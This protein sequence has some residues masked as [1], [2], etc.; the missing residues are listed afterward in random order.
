M[1]SERDFQQGKSQLHTLTLYIW[2]PHGFLVVSP[3]GVPLLAQEKVQLVGLCY[4]YTCIFLSFYHFGVD[5]T[6]Y[7]NLC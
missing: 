2:N 6:V 3:I 5:H 4:Y 1:C 7:V